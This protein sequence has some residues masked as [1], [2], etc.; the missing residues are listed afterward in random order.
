MKY[1]RTFV[2]IGSILFATTSFAEAGD[3][4][5]RFGAHYVDPKSDNHDIVSVDS[6][7]MI[8]FN[9]TYFMSDK[10]AVE[11][12]AALPY[13]HDIDLVGGGRV[14]ETKH[15]PPTLSVQYHFLPAGSVRPYLG[16]G[17][18]WTIFF[19]EDTTGALS[20]LDLSL[21]DAVGIAGQIGVDIDLTDRWFLNLEARYIDMSTKAKLDGVSIGDVDIDPW[22]FGANLGF[23][24]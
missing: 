10:W 4:L 17:V 23:R 6:A 9:G 15:L 21:D 7:T 16:V 8:T 3:W 14:A 18:N 24:F 12:L 11:L 19:E 2:L 1:T 5:V 20:G 22:L 13:T